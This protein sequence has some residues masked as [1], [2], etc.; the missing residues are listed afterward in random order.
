MHEFQM[1][2]CGSINKNGDKEGF[3]AAICEDGRFIGGL[4]SDNKP[5]GVAIIKPSVDDGLELGFIASHDGRQFY[6]G[7][8]NQKGEK[9]GYGIEWTLDQQGVYGVIHLGE[10]TRGNKS[11][12]EVS[13]KRNYL[14]L[15]Q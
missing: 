1:R 4:W 11:V 2:Y 10:W 7:T 12:V 6:V 8:I 15:T 14:M 9:H 3:G 5:D 13:F